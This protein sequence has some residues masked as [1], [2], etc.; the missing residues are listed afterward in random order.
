[1]IKLLLSKR[2]VSVA[3][4]IVF[5]QL[6]FMEKFPPA[7]ISGSSNVMGSVPLVSSS[8]HAAFG[9]IIDGVSRETFRTVMVLD[10]SSKII[11]GGTGSRMMISS[12][13]LKSSHW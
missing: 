2:N 8:T 9:V 3:L 11:L 12:S 5:E 10:S 1:M 7:V 6:A 4:A 13:L